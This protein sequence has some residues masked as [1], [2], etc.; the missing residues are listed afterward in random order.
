MGETNAS[1]TVASAVSGDAGS[2]TV[3][4]TGTCGVVTSSAA[5]VTLIGVKVALK[6]FLQG[7]Y[8]TGTMTPA[9]NDK[10][11]D[12]L[13]TT[14]LIPTTEPYTGLGFTH[15]SGGGNEQTTNAVLAV[16]G[17]DAIVDWVF[18]ELRSKTAPATVLHTR[19]ALIQRDGDVVDVDGTSALTFATAPGDNYYIAVKHRNHLG[20][21]PLS[22]VPLGATTTTFDFTDNSVTM[23]G[24]RP[25]L[26]QIATGVY[27]MYAGDANH[28]GVINSADK[29]GVWRLQN[30]L[31]NYL[32]AD[33]DF[34]GFV[35]AL[36]KNGFWINN[37]SLIQQLD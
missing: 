6:V 31:M 8:V 30:G 1:Y 7:P 33:F 29:N 36:D 4:V 17:N 23:Y 25:A 14:S 34:N 2:Y 18:I 27:G 32:G 24:N 13:R 22:S 19:S 3:V 21:R 26:K 9:N 12:G 10:M 20:F 15:Q 28:N 37:N 16:T 5:T 11:A 35:N